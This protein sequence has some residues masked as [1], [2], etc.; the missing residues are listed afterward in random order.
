M[1]LVEIIYA[2]I[3]LGIGF[4]IGNRGNK[5]NTN[6]YKL[7]RNME[8]MKLVGLENFILNMLERTETR[9]E[10]PEKLAKIQSVQTQIKQDREE[11]DDY[12]D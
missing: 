8:R 4:Y 3:G 1:V 12:L 2:I 5:N 6:Q 7:E 10:D 11:R 9:T